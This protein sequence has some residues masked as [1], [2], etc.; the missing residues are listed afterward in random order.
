MHHK[1]DHSPYAN[2]LELNKLSPK[3]SLKFFVTE[4]HKL[5]T[6]HFFLAIFFVK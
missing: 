2:N 5:S 4:H 3:Y 1:K 6:F